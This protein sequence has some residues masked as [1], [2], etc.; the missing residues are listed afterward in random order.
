MAFFYILPGLTNVTQGYFRGWGKTGVTLLGTLT[1]IGLRTI[2]TFVLLPLYGIK[3]IAFAS[4]IGWIGMLVW[5]LPYLCIHLS[6]VKC[7]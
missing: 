5:E 4:A 2:L 6:R 1:Q 3:G 7:K